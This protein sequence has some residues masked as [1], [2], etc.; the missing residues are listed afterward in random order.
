MCFTADAAAHLDL[1]AREPLV[2]VHREDAA[3]LVGLQ[4]DVVR[5][6]RCR[7]PGEGQLLRQQGGVQTTGQIQ[8]L[9]CEINES[10]LPRT[11]IVELGL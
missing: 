5:A 4:P 3:A 2:Q 8:A 6:C 1:S 7:G 11:S 10:L 9:L